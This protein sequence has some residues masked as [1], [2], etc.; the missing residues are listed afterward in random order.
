[1]IEFGCG[2]SIIEVSR[3][4]DISLSI[5]QPATIPVE[6][7]PAARVVAKVIVDPRVVGLPV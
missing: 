4:Q 6:T 1:M 3:L 2:V 5:L 7:Q